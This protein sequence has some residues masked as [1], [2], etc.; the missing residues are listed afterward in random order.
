VV[1]V[2]PFAEL[3]NPDV[4]VNY[5]SIQYFRRRNYVS[6]FADRL[7]EL[8]KSGTIEI[9]EARRTGIGSLFV[10]GYSL[11]VWRPR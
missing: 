11:V 5:L 10:D 3:L 4:L 8:E 7:L 2:E 6:G 9:I 1:H